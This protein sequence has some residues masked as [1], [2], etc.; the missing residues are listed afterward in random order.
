MATSD[1]I[2]VAHSAGS[3][4]SPAAT[5]SRV[6]LVQEKLAA[7]QKLE[8]EFL[9]CFRF[10]QIVQGQH[11][12]PEVS[13]A[14]SVR[15]LHA[16]WVCDCKDNLLSIP[17]SR[18][19]Y[20]GR[21]CLE[22][23]R[24]WQEG[25]TA[26]VVAFLQTKLD[27]L[28][29]ADLTAQIHEAWGQGERAIAE[30]L[31]HGRGVMLNRGFHLVL[32]LDAIFTPTD[33][34]LIREVRRASKELGHT[35]AQIE[36]QLVEMESIIYSYAPHPLL[37]RRNMLVMNELGIAVIDTPAD[38]PGNRTARVQ[39]P[40]LPNGPYAEQTIIGEMTLI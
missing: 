21:R 20:Q 32:A 30:R 5:E 18:D 13:V 19:R 25:N 24:L 39:V 7:F 29:C 9:D 1:N 27:N 22:L 40:R 34:Q 2:D 16:L 6:R 36:R 26:G 37:V 35:P 31:I 12:L 10:L 28:S 4:E 8:T 23:L 14:Q 38:L 15:L 11:R 17:L 3:E 33:D